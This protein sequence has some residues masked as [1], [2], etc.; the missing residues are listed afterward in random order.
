MNEGKSFTK[1]IED[2][3]KLGFSEGYLLAF[4]FIK[5]NLPLTV[6]EEM[7]FI[8]IMRKFEKK[9]DQKIKKTKR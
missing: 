8:E 2:Y 1:L 7:E 3:K 5:D 6:N 4:I 9:Y